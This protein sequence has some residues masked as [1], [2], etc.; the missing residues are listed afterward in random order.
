MLFL[1]L[2]SQRCS[3]GVLGVCIVIIE[4]FMTADKIVH[5]CMCILACHVV[6]MYITQTTST[7]HILCVMMSYKMEGVHA[8]K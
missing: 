6:V 3:V 8:D 1:H 7:H 4:V 5:I 2:I